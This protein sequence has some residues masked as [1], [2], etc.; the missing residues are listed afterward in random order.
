[1]N[2]GGH[3]WSADVA[4]IKSP[5]LVIFA[6]ADMMTLEHMAEIYRLLGGG[7][8]DAHYDGSLRP[9]PNQLAIIPGATHYNLMTAANGSATNYAKAF[10]AT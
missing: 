1:M 9:T 7:T 2:Q 3:D 5:T 8:R 4:N 6:D 10:L